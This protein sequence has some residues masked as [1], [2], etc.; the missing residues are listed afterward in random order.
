MMVSLASFSKTLL[1]LFQ[2]TFSQRDFAHYHEV[3][4]TLSI[5]LIC[6]MDLCFAVDAV[7]IEISKPV[8][9]SLYSTHIYA[10]GRA[11][12]MLRRINK[13]SFISQPISTFPS[14]GKS[15]AGISRFKG[16]GPFLTRPETS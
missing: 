4:N 15:Y 2:S 8:L 12:K 1:L 13:C 16:A 3:T 14:S 11:L 5:M 7:S 9:P 6:I 10:G